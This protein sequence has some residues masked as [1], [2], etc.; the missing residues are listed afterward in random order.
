MSSDQKEGRVKAFAILFALLGLAFS[1]LCLVN[2]SG[3]PPVE[4]CILSVGALIAGSWVGVGCLL[5]VLVDI[6][7]AIRG[8][9]DPSN[10]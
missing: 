7:D 6:R 8:R 1:V 3:G 9:Q 4:F 2:A 10:K 5:W